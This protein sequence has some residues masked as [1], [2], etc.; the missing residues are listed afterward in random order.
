L[1]GTDSRVSAAQQLGTAI[2]AGA[3]GDCEKGEFAG[4]GMGLLSLPFWAIAR[5]R[6]HC[7]K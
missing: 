3:R 1:D 6:D 2:A 4:G 5:L 7:G